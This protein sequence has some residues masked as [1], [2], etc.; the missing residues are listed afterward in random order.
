M[1]DEQLI[2]E[3]E[4]RTVLYDTTHPF[5][6]DNSR[7][8]KAWMEIA[9][10]LGISADVCKNRWRNLR[11]L[12]V[13][14]NK[15]TQLQNGSGGAPQKEWKYQGMMC[16]LQPFLQPRHSKS[17]LRPT[18]TVDLE[19]GGTETPLSLADT[20]ER[21][22]TPSST[23]STPST[24]GEG[25]KRSRSPRETPSRRLATKKKSTGTLMEDR[26]MCLLESPTPINTH[27]ESYH[28][29]LSTVPILTKL[30]SPRR[31]R[32]KREIMRILDDLTDEQEEER[33]S[34][35]A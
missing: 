11:D 4:N 16:F 32:A 34:A 8:E 15:K 33:G 19:L 26:I 6:K 30:S 17:S 1:D 22:S 7:K 23:Y 28:F 3:V 9:G 29:A 24:S 13:R 5:Y 25:K 2:V 20:E 18:P 35:Q 31:R 14:Y 27:E 10:T 12:F 21:A